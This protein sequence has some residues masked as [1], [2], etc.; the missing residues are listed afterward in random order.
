MASTT[1]IPV[2]PAAPG[3]ALSVDAPATA[4]A[5]LNA[6]RAG[7]I[8]V[9][10]FIV[11]VMVLSGMGQG[12]SQSNADAPAPVELEVSD[13]TLDAIVDALPE[14]TTEAKR[15]AVRESARKEL[16]KP[17]QADRPGQGADGRRGDGQGGGG[18]LGLLTLVFLVFSLLTVITGIWR[19]LA[20]KAP[21]LVRG[22]NAVA[23]PL[24]V[25][26]GLSVI[27]F[28]IVAL[29]D[30]PEEKRRPFN[31]LAVMGDYARADDVRLS[32]VTQ[33]EVTPRV[34]IDLVPEVG[35]KVVFV[36]PNFIEGG[37]FRRGETLLRVDPSDYEVAVISAEANLAN[38]RQALER[39]VAEGEL[40]K[41]DL[42][43]L[44]ISNPSQ[45]AMRRPQRQQA[46]AAVRAAEAEVSRAKLQLQRTSVRAPFDGR[47]R[48]KT[49]DLGQFVA[50]GARLGRIFSTNSVE[51][52]L[53]LT[54]ADLAKIDLPI[55][56]VATDL[57]SAPRVTLSTEIA[58]ERREWEARIVRTD[59]TYD[60]QTRALF[61]IAEVEDP[62]GRGAVDGVPLAP[63]LFVDAVVEGRALENVVVLPRDGLR[64]RDEVYVVDEDGK[65]EIR[66]V[67]V[68][69][70]SPTAAILRGGVEP[71]ELVVV[72][73][74]ERS[75]IETP[76]KVLDVNS[77]R[78]VLVDPPKPDW[79][80]AMEGDT[81]GDDASGSDTSSRSREERGGAD[82]D[83]DEAGSEAR[84]VRGDA[85]DGGSEGGE[86][87]GNGD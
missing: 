39:E 17:P 38:A 50:P 36:S 3:D 58:G 9:P 83:T 47:V 81:S 33:G 76:L 16:A 40:A 7:L 28:A 43:E 86:S 80:R 54:D 10:I 5:R 68:I 64:P 52:R 21:R 87:G 44:G 42:A 72:S 13:A 19:L 77:P 82:R 11:V 15:E 55:A 26:S 63:G 49:A 70:T 67:S 34:E 29:N 85:V 24:M 48:E 69:D 6:A 61:A 51:V 78:T 73:P 65:A 60:T 41:S 23:L 22:I 31:T 45:L 71:G 27:G 25:V 37:I 56:F 1:S 57:E 35:G 30:E 14:G 12:A 46:E 75:R 74:M 20:D 62:Y 18:P 59:A 4:T 32:V 2:S 84:A 79:M 8:L 53:P 66:S